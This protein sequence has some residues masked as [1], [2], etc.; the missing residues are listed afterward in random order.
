MAPVAA[1][2]EIG[3]PPPDRGG[4]RR[5][6]VVVDG[7][8]RA[9]SEI[10]ETLFELHHVG[11][12]GHAE[13]EGSPRAGHAEQEH[14]RTIVDERE[15]LPGLDDRTF[16]RERGVGPVATHD[17]RWGWCEAEGRVHELRGRR[18]RRGVTFAVDT[19]AAAV[20]GAT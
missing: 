12:V 18:G 7:D 5:G 4:G 16:G 8:V 11:T 10:D 20:A 3:L 13:R 2:T 6:E 17:H 9:V 19:V 1:F 14:D 15:R